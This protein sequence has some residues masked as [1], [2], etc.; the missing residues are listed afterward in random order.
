MNDNDI[1]VYKKHDYNAVKEIVEKLSDP[2][3]ITKALL[4]DI[5][6]NRMS[7]QDPVT[8]EITVIPPKFRITDYFDLPAKILPN[9][10]NAVPDTTLGIFLFN[11]FV[12]C[13]SFGSKIP[14]I[15]KT[16]DEKAIGGLQNKLSKMILSKEI[17]VDQYA[18]FTNNSVWLG[19]LNELVM[20]GMSVELIVPDKN[21]MKYKDKLLKE[22]PEL[23]EKKVVDLVTVAEYHD[24]IEKPLLDEA[25][26]IK[27]T[28]Y[29]GRIYEMK[30]PS[31]SNNYKNKSITNGAMF[32]PVTGKYKIN[33]N[34]FNDGVDDWNFDMLANKCMVASYNRGVNTQIGGTYAKYVGIMMQTVKA[35]PKGSDC[36]SKNYVKFRVTKDNAEIIVNSYGLF[37]ENGKKV[38]KEITDEIAQKLVGKVVSLRSPLFCKNPHYLCNKCIGNRFYNLGIENIG[39]TTNVPLD[40]QKL[41]SLKSMHDI[42]VK[43]TQIEPSEFIEFLS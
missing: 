1:L 9:Q 21:L 10:P 28:N 17:T 29:A 3:K 12:L 33:T 24:K 14:Y 4:T 19:Y 7:K 18:K 37:E 6:S 25:N 20:P 22:N 30:K 13:Q 27:D 39:L 36:G 42:S 41:K 5:F 34:S 43:T 35:G 11:S 40:A 8:K 38:E 31:F 26:K 15:N 32:D 16:L 2:K 23:T